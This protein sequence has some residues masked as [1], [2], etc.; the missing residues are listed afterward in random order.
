MWSQHLSSRR[1]LVSSCREMPTPAVLEKEP[2]NDGLMCHFRRRAGQTWPG[3]KAPVQVPWTREGAPAGGRSTRWTRSPATLMRT[4]HDEAHAMG[5][6]QGVKEKPDNYDCCALCLDRDASG[7]T[8]QGKK[9][10]HKTT[11]LGGTAHM[12]TGHHT[13]SKS[14][15]CARRSQ[16]QQLREGGRPPSGLT[17]SP[18]QRAARTRVVSHEGR[19]CRAEPPASGGNVCVCVSR[20]VFKK[21]KKEK[22]TEPS[23]KGKAHRLALQRR[24]FGEPLWLE[25][26]NPAVVSREATHRSRGRRCP[27]KRKKIHCFAGLRPIPDRGQRP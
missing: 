21:E 8:L 19:R 9:K 15:Q 4:S 13:L 7:Q 26:G 3:E 16:G 1:A 20:R 27:A 10:R 6:G 23:K 2:I 18:G 17:A 25:A 14:H 5:S 22:E 11:G 24:V 12:G